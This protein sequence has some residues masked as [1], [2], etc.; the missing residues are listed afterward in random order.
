[1]VLKAT[2][3]DGVYDKDP[4]KFDD[5]VKL[6]NVSFQQSVENNSI[7]VMDKAALGL[8]LEQQKPIVVFDVM[9][10]DNLLKIAQGE[11]VGTLID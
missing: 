9:K 2:K 1:L 6:D 3:Y 5:A 11:S 10:P 8:A 4:A 7:Q